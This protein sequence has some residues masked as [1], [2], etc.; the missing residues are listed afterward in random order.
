MST[1]SSPQPSPI[2]F[3]D[4]Y[5]LRL[6]Y[7]DVEQ[8]NKLRDDVIQYT[9]RVCTWEDVLFVMVFDILDNGNVLLN[10]LSE[11]LFYRLAKPNKNNPI[12]EEVMR[13]LGLSENDET[14]SK[15][16]TAYNNLLMEVYD[17]YGKLIEGV[18]KS[19]GKINRKA[20]AFRLQR[21]SV[22][23]TGIRI[24]FTRNTTANPQ[25]FIGTLVSNVT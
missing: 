15:F 2:L 4:I 8:L 16:L 17:C 6:P 19:L 10:K 20:S 5:V 9:Q 21:V 1:P 22:L 7:R 23:D 24:M 11:E 14:F 18:A 12:S 13:I 25:G 3:S